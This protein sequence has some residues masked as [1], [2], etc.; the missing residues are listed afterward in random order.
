MQSSDSDF[1]TSPVWNDDVKRIVGVLVFVV[2]ALLIFQFSA[3]IPLIFTAIILSYLFHPVA[4]AI[5]D[6]LLRGRL[7]P[8][9]V[10]LTFL[11]VIS[12]IILALLFVIPTLSSQIQSLVASIPAFLSAVQESV[13]EF[14]AGEID[15]RGALLE[16]VFPEPIVVAQVLG[17]NIS[18]DGVLE[19][20]DAL[21]SQLT[22][23]DPVAISQQLAGSVGQITGSAFNFL[24]GAVSIGL[25][26]VFLLTMTFYLMTDGKNMANALVKA[27]PDGYQDDT[28]RMLRELGKVWNSYLRGQV[29]LSLIMGVAMYTM[30]TVLGIPNALFLAIFA[31]LMEFIPNLGP[32]LATVPAA[33][34]A[35]FTSSTTIE[36]LSGFAFALVVVLVWTVLQQMEAVVLIPRI[37]GDSLNLHPFVV[38]VAVLGGISVGGIFAV[39]IAAPVVASMRLIAQYVYGKLTGRALFPVDRRTARQMRRER[40]PLL[41]R[42]GDYCARWVRG[43]LSSRLVTK[44]RD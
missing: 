22:N 38:L 27:A 16:R 19:I 41:V 36:P 24:G 32:A 34:I 3:I 23:F 4:D 30:A 25:N 44:R 13:L 28:R 15:L 12:T 1:T 7:R 2:G 43:L 39:L 31:G 42:F 18:E 20:F 9:A 26:T 11:M 35:L 6:G 17:I 40:R 10:L 29:I 5:Q 33:T 21:E 14:L 37:V 8:L